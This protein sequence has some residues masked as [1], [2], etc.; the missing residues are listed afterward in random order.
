MLAFFNFILNLLVSEYGFIPDA[1][2]VF[3]G[4]T[5]S[6]DYHHEMNGDHFEEYIRTRLAQNCLDKTKLVID[7]A[8]YHLV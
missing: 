8:S 4:K 7:K 5:G 2:N 1:L 6:G 3:V